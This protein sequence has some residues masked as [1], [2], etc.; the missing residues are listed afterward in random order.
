M[1]RY[2]R[3][4]HQLEKMSEHIAELTNEQLSQVS[5]GGSSKSRTPPEYLKITLQ[6]VIV[7]S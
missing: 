1:L 5:G 2:L 3:K 6:T 7:S 4:R